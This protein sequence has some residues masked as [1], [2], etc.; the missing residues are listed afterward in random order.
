MS[1]GGE[2]FT[3]KLDKLL[4]PPPP[5]KKSKKAAEAPLLVPRPNFLFGKLSEA[6]SK[7]DDKKPFLLYL[8]GDDP[9]SVIFETKI[10]I[11]PEIIKL[12]VSYCLDVLTRAIERKL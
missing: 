9:T 4:N 11:K 1:A 5:G 12:M 2:E 8:S 7:I 3:V 6:I 10:L